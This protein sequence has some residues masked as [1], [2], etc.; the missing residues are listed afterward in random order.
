MKP[1]WW[2]VLKLLIVGGP[3][4]GLAAGWRVYPRA[5]LVRLALVPALTSMVLLFRQ[6]ALFVVLIVDALCG[7]LAAL[8]LLSLPRRRH[9]SVERQ[10]GRVLSLGK[11]HHVTL[12]V[13][14]HSLREYRFE[15][16]D[17][18]PPSLRGEP[19]EFTETVHARSRA[20]L[21]YKLHSTRR[22]A[23][24]FETVH[25]R[26]TSRL[27]FWQRQI[28]CAAPATI[29]VYP[30]LKQLSDYALLARKNR[31]SLLGLRRTRKIG[32]DN[33]FERMRDF[34]LDDNYKHINW[35]ATARRQKLTVKDFQVNQSQRI[36]FL[37]D[38]GRMMTNEAADLTLLDHSFNAMLMLAY[39]ALSHGD[40]VGLLCF[41][42][43]IH[44]FIPPASGL[45]QMNRLLHATFDRFPKLVESR[46]DQAFVYLGAHCRK[47]SLVILVTNVI[48]QVNANQIEEYL[49][50]IV[51]RHLPLGVI[52]RDRQLFRALEEK[53]E[54]DAALYRAAAAADILSWRQQVL[55][56]L[57][58]HGAMA[59]DVFPEEMTAPLINQYLEIKA[60]HLL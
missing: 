45:Q 37:L 30:D 50:T 47:R 58:S 21:D 41:S 5:R 2:F 19:A 43:E 22:G 53:H 11:P 24:A 44:S 46:Y 28:E 60:R 3:L 42:D 9:I 57:Q 55:S 52:L 7:L 56:D 31:L 16:K 38:C 48:D 1:L 12:I 29:N 4:A 20:L 25:L 35:R 18:I 10:M 39:V 23:F 6:D 51:G 59:L 40:A 54:S 8:D 26:A 17:D 33:E 13:N 15:I 36:V 34:T 49:T 32:Q 27:G 14:N